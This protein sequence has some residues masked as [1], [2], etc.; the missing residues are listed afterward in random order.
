MDRPDNNASTGSQEEKEEV[1]NIQEEQE[2]S[3]FNIPEGW[4]IDAHYM[5]VY[6]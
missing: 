6:M 1:N 5:R 3:D 4:P 2:K